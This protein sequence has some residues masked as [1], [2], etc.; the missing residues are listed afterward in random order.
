[1]KSNSPKG[2]T[3]REFLEKTAKLCFAIGLSSGFLDSCKPDASR[4]ETPT[5]AEESGVAGSDSEPAYLK[6]HTTGELLERAEKLWA[7]MEGCQLCPRKC[8]VNRLEGMSDSVVP[9]VQ[10][11]SLQGLI[12]ILAKRNHSLEVVVQ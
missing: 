12:R 2:I 9:L 1:M 7:I 6:L 3:R 5:P 8:G 11:L 10:H 4:D